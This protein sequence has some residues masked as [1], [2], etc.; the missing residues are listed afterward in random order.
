MNHHRPLIIPVAL[1][2]LSA[3]V[4]ACG[5]TAAPTIPAPAGK[6]PGGPAKPAAEQAWDT[7]VA[8]AKKEG[9]VSVYALWRPETRAGLTQAFKDRYDIDVEFSPFSR[10]PEMLA[11]VQ[12]EQRAGLFVADL[13]G[14]GGPSLVAT[15]KPQGILGQIEP[16][17]VLPEATDPKNWS[18][19]KFPY[20][21]ADKT[22]VGM[23]AS[24][25]RY[26]MFNT[27]LIK[28]GELTTYRDVLKPQYRG[29][30]TLND[31]LVTGVGNAFFSHLAMHITSEE[32]AKDMLRQLITQQDVVIQRDNRTHVESV[33]RG[34]YAIG[35]AP[36]PDNMADFLKL[37]A[38]IDAVIVKEGTFISPA[39]G[40]FAVPPKLAHPNAAK[41]FV[42]W[43]LTKEGQGVFSRGF[44]NPSL[45][46]DVP[47]AEFHSMFLP[48]P[49]EKIFLDSE[50]SI[51]YRGKWLTIAKQVI[52]ETTRK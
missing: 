14:A 7:V 17:L 23:I 43:L 31:P 33:A 24:V 35:V 8:E 25:Q 11:R 27:D 42:N 1:L 13:L 41:L 37:G 2:L 34:K 49:G 46:G 39:A 36:N 15:M 20:L 45:R 30:I 52:D 28:K 9:K 4:F 44:G 47:T 16:L 5:P 48:Q 26:L 51:L 29:K 3:L 50:D 18:G 32:D 12:S 40:A 19:G 21:D 22:S 6:A 10:G 38:P